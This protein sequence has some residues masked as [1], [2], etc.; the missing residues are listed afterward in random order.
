V[1]DVGGNREI[2]LTARAVICAVDDD[3][4]LAQKVVSLLKDGN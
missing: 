2:V 3:L 1:S 4:L